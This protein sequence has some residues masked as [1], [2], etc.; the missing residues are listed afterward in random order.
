MS[1][2]LLNSLEAI[3][4]D[5]AEMPDAITATI[6]SI[7]DIDQKLSDAQAKCA[8]AERTVSQQIVARLGKNK[9]D[10]INSTQDAVRSLAD[11]Q[12]ALY[13]AQILL[14]EYQRKLSDSMRF[15]LVLGTSSIAMNR[16]VIAE[17]EG[18]LKQA[19]KEELSEKAR[20]ELL[21]VIKLLKEQESAFS[22]QDR[23]ADEIDSTKRTVETHSQEISQIHLT[24]Q[25][26]DEADCR[27]DEQI[28]AGVQKDIEQDDEISRQRLVDTK[29]EALLHRIKIIAI[30]GLCIASIALTLSIINFFV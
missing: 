22:R 10:A 6:H 2:N 13:E 15:L 30:W 28:A 8:E 25:R 5:E 14:F 21:E 12:A 19:T 4:I 27:H 26:Q 20:K 17:L 18:K 11:A 29:H 16:L 3:T 23:L 9:R 7:V 24:D 1:E